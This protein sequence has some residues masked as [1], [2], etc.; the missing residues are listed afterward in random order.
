MSSGRSVEGVAGG[1][2]VGRGLAVGVASRPLLD[3]LSGLQG[4]VEAVDPG[5]VP[6]RD[7]VDLVRVLDRIG[8]VADAAKAAAAGRVAESSLWSKAGHRSPAHWVA[9]ET[10]IGVGEAIKLLETAEV[11]AAAPVV[12]RGA[13]RLVWC[14][15][16]RRGRRLG[17]RRRSPVRATGWWRRRGRCRS[18]SSRPTPTGSWPPRRASH[19]GEKAE[20]HR[21]ARR[22][23]HGVDADGMGYGRL[24]GADRGAHPL[25]R[26][27]RGRA[28]DRCS[29]RPGLGVIVSRWR[30]TPPTR[31]SGSSTG[32]PAPGP[33][34]RSRPGAT[35]PLVALLW[36]VRRMWRR[37]GGR[38]LVVHE[39]DRAGRPDRPRPRCQVA[40]GEVCEIAGQ[41]PIPVADAWRMIDGDA[42]VAAVTTKGTE[43]DKVVHLGRKPTVLQKTASGVVLRRGVLHRGVHQHRPASRSTTSPTGPT[44]RSPRCPTWR[45]RVGTATTSRPTG[46]T[47][48]APAS[49]PGNARL[50][51]PEGADP[52]G[53]GP[54]GWADP[55]RRRDQPG[56][57]DTS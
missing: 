55:E 33:W 34:R 46:A 29:P 10:G 32:R 4:F 53:E 1:D 41:G 56:L 38:G 22:I 18:P 27:A 54:V 16:V 37:R 12:A 14:R 44:P 15:R 47:P 5:Q 43:I 24:V 48:S 31:S 13:C 52:P 21:K 36:R 2:A 39:D 42:F 50:I 9:K 8:R 30:P 26:P 11:V 51:P 19:R 35:V 45:R 25:G 20:R 6:A 3:V 28:A 49:P 17:R 23:F 40:A 7:A 57:F